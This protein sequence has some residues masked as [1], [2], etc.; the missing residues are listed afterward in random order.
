MDMTLEKLEK[1]SDQELLDF[2]VKNMEETMKMELIT[3][4]TDKIEDFKKRFVYTFDDIKKYI[5]CD[6]EKGT[7]TVPYIDE[8]EID[9]FKKVVFSEKGR[10]DR[11]PWKG[12]FNVLQV[13]VTNE[14]FG[15]VTTNYECLKVN[16]KDDPR[17][18]N[19]VRNDRKE[20]KMYFD[21]KNNVFQQ[22]PDKKVQDD[23]EG[24]Q[25]VD[26]FNRRNVMKDYILERLEE[27]QYRYLKA[28]DEIY[29]LERSPGQQKEKLIDYYQTWNQFFTEEMEQGMQV[30]LV[31]THISLR[32]YKVFIQVF[33]QY[34][35]IIET[36][37][38][39]LL[40]V[41]VN[42]KGEVDKDWYRQ[43]LESVTLF[44]TD[45]ISERKENK[46]KYGFFVW[47]LII[48]KE[49]KEKKT[50]INPTISEVERRSYY[51]DIASKPIDEER[52]NK[53][54]IEY[55]TNKEESKELKVIEKPANL[56]KGD[57]QIILS[58]VKD[59]RE[60]HNDVALFFDAVANK[61]KISVEELYQYLNDLVEE[62]NRKERE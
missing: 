39:Q 21:Y 40:S 30:S 12:F 2:S 50:V 57:Y 27:L 20:E 17:F 32:E 51:M 9:I 10:S 28:F 6:K 59:R 41:S 56:E 58:I 18:P 36:K 22:V 47:E 37:Y 8:R 1:M 44:L 61:S 15:L 46:D 62:R 4:D 43:E 24:N 49:T 5:E 33:E 25:H 26:E 54:V 13:T 7:L 29:G 53:A 11:I 38:N 23:D 35:P 14:L 45:F 16:R 60:H 31:Y 19:D 3:K 42:E 52:K 55:L 48:D 34:Q